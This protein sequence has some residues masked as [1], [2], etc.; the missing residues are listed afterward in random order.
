VDL[1]LGWVSF[2]LTGWGVPLSLYVV[3]QVGALLGTEGPWRISAAAPIPLMAVVSAHMAW[4]YL[5]ESNLWPMT[6]LMTAPGAILAVLVVWV[7][8]LLRKRKWKLL[9]LPAAACASAILAAR[10]GGHGIHLFSADNETLTIAGVLVTLG[11]LA[12]RVFGHS[13]RVID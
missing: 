13:G 7:A 5:Q 11:A 1:V 6:M 10:I 8:A 4:A 9:A 12:A 3:L 2:F